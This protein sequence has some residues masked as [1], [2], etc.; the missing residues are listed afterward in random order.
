MNSHI[1]KIFKWCKIQQ[2][3]VPID[4]VLHE[5]HA[6]VAHGYIPDEM[7]AVK[8]PLDGKYYTS[9]AKFRAVTKSHGYEEVGTAYE[10]GYDPERIRESSE[11][12][13]IQ[14]L[15]ESFKERYRDGKLRNRN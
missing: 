3:V 5:V 6:N 12:A 13:K 11:N 4:E 2:K 1:G 14:R 15:A 8:H 10:N 7:G 9:K